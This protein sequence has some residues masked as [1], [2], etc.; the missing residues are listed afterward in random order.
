MAA[1]HSALEPHWQAAE[2]SGIAHAFATLERGT[3]SLCGR[4]VPVDARF[5]Y[6][7]L[8]ACLK[9][10]AVIENTRKAKRSAPV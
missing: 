7:P 8:A 10:L 6:P 2:R 1:V 5:L 4:A 9:C 3:S